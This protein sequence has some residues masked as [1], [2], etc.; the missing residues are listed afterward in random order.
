MFTSQ[1]KRYK[2][3]TT[4]IGYHVLFFIA[5]SRLV[6]FFELLFSVVVVGFVYAALNFLLSTFFNVKYVYCMYGYAL[7][8]SGGIFR[9]LLYIENNRVK[10][11][12]NDLQKKN[13]LL[14]PFVSL[15]VGIKEYKSSIFNFTK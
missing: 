10:R 3:T 5:R 7:A 1:K 13:L 12:E 11:F 6:I 2:R 14:S 15:S 8:L 9:Q 4:V